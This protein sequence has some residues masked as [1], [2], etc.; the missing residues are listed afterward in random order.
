MENDVL[1]AIFTRRSCRNFLDESVNRK[2]VESIVAA[3]LCAPSAM[4]QQAWQFTV[5]TDR[6]KLAQL[7]DAMLKT[8]DEAAAARINA[9]SEGQSSCF[10]HA[11]V[12]IVVSLASDA[13]FP[14]SDAACAIE[15][16]YLA[17]HALGL[18]AC[19]INQLTG[20][21]AEPLKK[22][23]TRLGVPA[24]HTVYGSLAV[25]KIGKE[26]LLK[27]RTGKVVWVE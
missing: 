11:P 5:L 22:E 1:K 16:M 12:L 14:Y 25:G 19:W 7:N 6:E 20:N 10:Y 24:D 9:R 15:N 17:A 8:L 4:N 18:G 13:I 27:Q 23:L 3:G 2:E 26:S 21:S